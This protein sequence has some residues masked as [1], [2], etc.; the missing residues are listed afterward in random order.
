MTDGPAVLIER[1]LQDVLTRWNEAEDT[2]RETER[3]LRRVIDSQTRLEREAR[4]LRVALSA[5]S[6]DLMD[7][8]EADK[9]NLKARSE[10][11]RART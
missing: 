2:K 10:L 3:D 5:L 6:G 1:S 7:E 8:V 11:R 4:G 9:E